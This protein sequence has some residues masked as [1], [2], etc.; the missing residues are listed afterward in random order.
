MSHLTCLDATSGRVTWHIDLPKE[1][2]AT[3]DLRGANCSPIIEGNLL[4]LVIAKSPQTSIIAFDKDTG[5]QV[6]EALDEIPSDSS[7]IVVTSAG[8]RQL[9]VWAHKSVAALDPATGVILWRQPVNTGG[10][11][12][13]ATPVWEKDRLLLGG[14]MLQLATDKPAASVVWPAELRPSRI[15]VSHTSTAL[16]HD[17][18]ILAPTSKGEVRCL[19]AT[20]GKQLW[21]ADKVSESNSGGSIH[22]TAAVSTGC[23][24][25]FTDRGDLILSRATANGYQEISRVHLIEPTSDFGARKMAWSPPSYADRCV[26]VRNDKELL[27]ASLASEDYRGKE[28]EQ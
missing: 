22:I 11:Y 17:G 12:A 9:I 27:C 24:F 1:F 28:G 16:M 20:T 25:L 26:F 8:R 3:E 13:V 2:G 15:L 19:D 7:P 10:T 5:R 23:V 4:I 21:Q 14:L 6:W 18:L